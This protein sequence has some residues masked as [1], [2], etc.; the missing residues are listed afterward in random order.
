MSYNH[1]HPKNR[2]LQC[3]PTN[4]RCVKGAASPL[5]EAAYKDGYEVDI[6]VVMAKIPRLAP[7]ILVAPTRCAT[8]TGALVPFR[9]DFVTPPFQQ[10]QTDSR[11][12][13]SFR[14][15][16][17]SRN[18]KIWNLINNAAQDPVVGRQTGKTL[19]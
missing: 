9:N 18:W 6:H 15:Q 7:M 12:F 16:F 14:G 17:R 10:L 19:S 8:F 13:A 2:F 5:T 11:P 1:L 3:S 4:G